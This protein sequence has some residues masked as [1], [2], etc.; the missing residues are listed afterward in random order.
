M[1]PSV[2]QPSP[3]GRVPIT[4]Q[5]ISS[6]QP[7]SSGQPHGAP[8]G[9]QRQPV[10]G[11]QT[12][13]STFVGRQPST[14]GAHQPIHGQQTP[15]QP[16]GSTFSGRQPST[17]GVR[18]PNQ[19]QQ[20]PQQP[21]GSTFTGRQPSTQGVN[22]PIQGQQTPGQSP[23]S[24]F[25]GRQPSTQG[26]RQPVQGQFQPNRGPLTQPGQQSQGH[27]PSGQSGQSHFGGQRPQTNS[28]RQPVPQAV[29]H[30]TSSGNP[31]LGPDGQPNNVAD[32]ARSMGLNQFANWVTNTGLLE[33]IHDGG[34]YISNNNSPYMHECRIIN[35]CVNCNA[36]HISIFR[37]IHCFCSY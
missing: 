19:G 33:K 7:T 35:D 25:R 36:I 17:Q 15:G 8:F 13:G 22:Q 2:G 37:S 18:H 20:T 27:Q 9:G 11:Q 21:I 1:Q 29:G 31:G 23:G 3:V 16:I 32:L 5:G 30:T 12:P 6:N 26:A 24:T 34:N 14:Q 10:H 4:G 28:Q